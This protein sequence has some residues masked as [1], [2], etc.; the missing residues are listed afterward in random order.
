MTC[1]TEFPRLAAADAVS[2]TGAPTVAVELL[3]GAVSDTLVP[4]TAVTVIALEVELPPALSSTRAVIVEFAAA[5][6]V[7]DTE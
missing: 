4:V 2:V 1:V 6:G 3:L 7:H 5:E